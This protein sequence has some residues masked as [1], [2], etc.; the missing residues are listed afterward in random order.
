MQ[1]QSDW[2][3]MP[4]RLLFAG[5]AHTFISFVHAETHSRTSAARCPSGS[6]KPRARYFSNIS[7]DMQAEMARVFLARDNYL[8]FY[9]G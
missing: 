9:W 4:T 3:G 7:D 1:S 6:E 2:Q 8:L 5:T